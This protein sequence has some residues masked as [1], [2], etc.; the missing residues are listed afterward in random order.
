METSELEQLMAQPPEWTDR[1]NRPK[2][3][4]DRWGRDHWNLFS[5][6]HS[7]IAGYSGLLDWR[8]V[9]ISSSH[10]PMLWAA[11]VILGP[12]ASADDYAELYGLRLKEAD[13]RETVLKGVCEVDALMDMVDAGLITITMPPPDKDGAHFLKPDGSPLR[14]DDSPSP[15]FVTGQAE[16]KLMPWAKFGLTSR[17]WRVIQAWSEHRGTDGATCSNFKAPA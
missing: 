12:Y 11:R 5:Y 16:W 3:S 15:R 9:G 14:G 10:W 17:G 7:R 1:T 4:I 6:I 8:H 13:D 2:I